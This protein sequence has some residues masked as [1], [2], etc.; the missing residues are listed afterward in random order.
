[1]SLIKRINSLEPLWWSLF[2]I[3]GAVAAFLF[4]L[5]IFIQGVAKPLGLVSPDILNYDQLHALF[6][7]PVISLIVKLYL[8]ALI[9]FPLFH[10]AH[11]I[12]LTLEDLRMEWLDHI[13]P[14]FCYG[15]ATVLTIVTIIVIF[16]IH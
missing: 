11:R 14:L 8:F 12:R 3:G 7:S 1:M 16:Q 5:H 4:P 6:Q 10:A 2:G 9:V 13:L 15:G